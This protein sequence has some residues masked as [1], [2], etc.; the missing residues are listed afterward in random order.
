MSIIK[1]SE[2][3][4]IKEFE[5]S[6]IEEMK[7]S[8]DFLNS[9]L[10]KIRTN[11]VNTSLIEDIKIAIHGK[12]IPL[13]GL[14]V[15]TTPD[16]CTLSIQPFDISNIND[17]EK[18]LSQVNLGA[19]AKNDGKIIKITV[20]PMSKERR[21]ELIKLVGKKKDEALIGIRKIRQEILAT[22]KQ[23]EKD[24]KISEDL[25]TKLQKTLQNGLD[26]VTLILN[27]LCQKKEISLSE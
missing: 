18:A 4:S 16:A 6:V 5:K 13:K 1:I 3:I 14:S 19:Q 17:I 9:E 15:I 24:K 2:Q 23:T 25:S 21:L 26:S 27:S 20:P 8:A 22:I 7:K 11:K 10:A 12:N